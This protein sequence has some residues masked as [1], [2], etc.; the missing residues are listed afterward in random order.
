MHDR[1]LY[2]FSQSSDS[3]VL[4]QIA[5][6]KRDHAVVRDAADRAQGQLGNGN[7]KQAQ[8]L[9]DAVDAVDATFNNAV[10]TVLIGISP[11]FALFDAY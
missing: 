9:Q 6:L 11:L 7:E 8:Y 5:K 1:S 4:A 2:R 3:P 10:E